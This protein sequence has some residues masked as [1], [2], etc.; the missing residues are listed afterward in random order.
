[1]K[2]DGENKQNA[3]IGN[4]KLS[5]ATIMAL[6]LL[7]SSMAFGADVLF[8]VGQK[9]MK[10]IDSHIKTSLID[11]G[12]SVTVRKDY[13][14]SV[15]DTLDKDLLIISDS[16]VANKIQI[17]LRDL[18][19]PLICSEAMLFD[20][21]GM[22]RQARFKD[23]GRKTRQQY[24]QVV[25]SDHPLAAALA[26]DVQVSTQGL[27]MG[28]GV[29]SDDAIKVA[30]MRGNQDRYPIFAYDAGAKMPDQ[31]AP[32]KR[33]GF[34]LNNNTKGDIT[35]QG[36]ALFDAAVD[37]AASDALAVAQAN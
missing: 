13:A 18:H 23:F 35:D 4:W 29:P 32:A 6:M 25:K 24:V 33:V 5:L 10:A 9:K 12:F 30:K 34:F 20:D 19:V 27:F 1:M 11:K 14:V 28:W 22:T 15:E 7:T 8:I 36:W 31:A 17:D 2:Q 21:L 3:I 37:W 16:V 26:D